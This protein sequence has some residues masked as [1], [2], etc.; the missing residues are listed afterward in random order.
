MPPGLSKADLANA[1]D[2]AGDSAGVAATGVGTEPAGGGRKKGKKGKKVAGPA[3]PP[4]EHG[5]PAGGG[6]SSDDDDF[7]F[8]PMPAQVGATQLN[9]VRDL[10]NTLQMFEAR[11][12]AARQKIVDPTGGKPA[13]DTWMTELPDLVRKN[14]GVS[15]TS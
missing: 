15:A 6:S 7:G 14:L 12:K 4:Q 5:R 9:E 2:A 1:A 3:R 11:S 8:G 13:R 10:V